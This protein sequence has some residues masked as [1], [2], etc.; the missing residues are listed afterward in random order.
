MINFAIRNKVNG[1]VITNETF[2]D[3]YDDYPDIPLLQGEVFMTIKSSSYNYPILVDPLEKFSDD[4]KKFAKKGLFQFVQK[5]TKGW[6]T[7]PVPFGKDIY[8]VNPFI[9]SDDEEYKEYSED[10]RTWKEFLKD[11]LPEYDIYTVNASVHDD[12]Q[13]EICRLDESFDDFQEVDGLILMEKGAEMLPEYA[14]LLTDWFNGYFS[15]LILYVPNNEPSKQIHF[16]RYVYKL[17]DNYSSEKNVA[18]MLSAA[19]KCNEDKGIDLDSNNWEPVQIQKFT[20]L[21]KK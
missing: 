11:E 21:Y 20:D 15:A 9:E 4:E 8:E 1:R 6:H 18:K 3:G 10:H 5:I 17:E 13:F 19:F 7:N 2:E 14:D 16:L 12:V